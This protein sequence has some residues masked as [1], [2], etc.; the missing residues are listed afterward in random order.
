MRTH[1]RISLSNITHN[2]KLLRGFT[3]AHTKM[4]AGSVLG[5][6]YSTPRT[7]GATRGP[8]VNNC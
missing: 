6:Y 2:I 7:L 4:I 5:E 1:L 3:D 8:I